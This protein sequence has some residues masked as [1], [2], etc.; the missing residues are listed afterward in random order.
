MFIY[1]NSNYV[2]NFDLSTISV[3]MWITTLAH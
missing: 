1:N 2:D 3:D